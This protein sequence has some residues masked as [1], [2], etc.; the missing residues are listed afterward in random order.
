MPELTGLVSH[1]EALDRLN[2]VG[3]GDLE[4]ILE[5]WT[6]APEGWIID[7]SPPPGIPLGQGS[8]D[9]LWL[10]PTGTAE[11]PR[12]VVAIPPG[13]EVETVVMPDLVGLAS[14]GAATE[15]YHAA[16]CA[17]SVMFPTPTWGPDSP[18]PEGEIVLQFPPAGEPLVVEDRMCQSP[19]GTT[20]NVF[21]VND[22]YCAGGAGSCE[23]VGY[24]KGV[25]S[26]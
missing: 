8:L 4:I 3:C 17:G 13:D 9:C 23:P 1:A 21:Y 10:G 11:R 12:V 24:W 15:V 16:G 22:D 26:D 2:E 19:D 25:L 7:Q 14:V 18:R 6:S 20:V 5:P